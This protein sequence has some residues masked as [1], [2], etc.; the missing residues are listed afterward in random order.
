M[1]LKIGIGLT[2]ATSFLLASLAAARQNQNDGKRE[3]RN[4]DDDV[5]VKA[6]YVEWHKPATR[7]QKASDLIGKPVKNSKGENLGKIENLAIDPKAGRVLYA[8]LSFGGMMGVGDKN[9]AIPFNALELPLDATHFVMDV[10][11][12]RLK[13]AQGFDKNNWPNMADTRWARETFEYYGKHFVDTSE[14]SIPK[15]T[16]PWQKATD[17]IGKA[18]HNPQGENLG[19]LDDIIVNP[20]NGRL[21]LGVGAFGGFLGMGES[22]HAVPWTA[23]ELT[24]DYKNFILN[25]DRE[26]LK[27]APKFDK[28]KWPNWASEP[29]TREVY[30][31][32]GTPI[33]WEQRVESERQR[34]DGE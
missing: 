23:L 18:I 15:P 31:F 29:V 5:A 21:I 6:F 28:K 4:T 17:L 32:Y 26:R 12:D 14:K 24:T 30:V 22:L 10:D 33:Y 19:E 16:G 27:N 8:V 20:D 3:T 9:F 25:V 13:N 2:I 7:T 34:R 1:K 11:K